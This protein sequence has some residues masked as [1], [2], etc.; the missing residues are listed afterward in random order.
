MSG[1]GVEDAITTLLA[2]QHNWIKRKVGSM[3]RRQFEIV[4]AAML[5][6]QRGLAEAKWGTWTE[7][8]RR[9]TLV[10]LSRS[11]ASMSAYQAAALMAE[12]PSIV[13]AGQR[14]SARWL[15]KL[16]KAFNGSV[17]PLRFDTLEWWENKHPE[18]GQ[19]RLRQFARSFE[20]YGAAAV[21]ATE[22]A[23]AKNV[24]LGQ[25]WWDV[26]DEVWKHVRHSVGGQSW[27]VDRILR[28]ETSAVYNGTMLAA[29]Q[30]E[31]DEEDRMHKRLAATFDQSTGKD[32]VLLDGQIK[33]VGEPFF[34]SYHGFEYMAPPNRPNDREIVIGWRSSYGDVDIRQ[35]SAGERK[36]AEKEAQRRAAKRA[37]RQGADVEV[38]ALER[39]ESSLRRQV[40]QFADPDVRRSIRAQLGSVQ[41]Q[42][43]SLRGAGFV[44]SGTA[45]A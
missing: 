27:K 19:V 9:G 4:R 44:A 6:V 30:D 21:K 36:A 10:M 32:S 13:K 38:A 23:L 42:L 34:D 8:E 5:E 41:R 1:G 3:T 31:D 22:E 28:T 39:Q 29:L 25:P 12:V 15:R 24:L 35:A 37:R 43:R 17:R 33:P 18:F 45:R 20:R 40:T 26:R 7:A 16:D 14:H 2:V 11:M